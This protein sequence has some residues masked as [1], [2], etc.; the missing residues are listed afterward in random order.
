VRLEIPEH[1]DRLGNE[2][3]LVLFRILQECLTNIHRHSGSKTATLRIGSDSQQAWLEV[4]D[5][6][7]GS[8]DAPAEFQ[9]GIGITGMRERVKDL[10]GVLEISSEG[11]GTRVRAVLP[12]APR[13]SKSATN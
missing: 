7:K 8:G 1:L 3:E 13:A 9:P 4:Q 6:G 12:L 2:V 11:T 5:Q 10:S